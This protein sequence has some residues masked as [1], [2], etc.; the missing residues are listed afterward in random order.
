MGLQLNDRLQMLRI[1][2]RPN[3]SKVGGKRS[4]AGS[5]RGWTGFRRNKPYVGKRQWNLSTAVIPSRLHVCKPGKR[6]RDYAG[7]VPQLVLL[8]RA[9]QLHESYRTQVLPN[10]GSEL[11]SPVPGHT[12]KPAARSKTPGGDLPICRNATH[13]LE[14]HAPSCD[15]KLVY[16]LARLEYDVL[17]GDKKGTRL[18]NR[19]GCGSSER[20]RY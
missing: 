11:G 17:D 18:I 20:Q 9:S 1:G 2:V 19:C 16:A 10:R 13:G 14:G 3:D 6:R 7:G 8:H 5:I 15:F 4:S 12:S